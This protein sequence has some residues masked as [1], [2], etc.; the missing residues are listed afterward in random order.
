MS[1]K[2][3]ES[4][5]YHGMLKTSSEVFNSEIEFHNDWADSTSM[6]DRFVHESFESPLALENRFAL[7]LMGDLK[8]KKLLDVGT[9]LG[10][11]AVYFALQGAEVTA[12]DISPRMI[13]RAKQLA[14]YHQTQIKGIVCPAEKLDLPDNHVDICYAANVLHHVTDRKSTLQEIHR[15]LKPN[16]LIVSWDP[17]AYN[18]MINVYRW[19]ADKVR[20]EHEKPLGFN[21]VQEYQEFFEH[22]EHHEF[23]LSA[24]LI[25]VK[26]Y[27]VDRIH[28]NQDRY[29]KRILK[30]GPDTLAW[31]KPLLSLD[32]RLLRFPPLRYMA[33]TILV[34]ARKGNTVAQDG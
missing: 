31:L 16:G 6:E 20:T 17:L 2:T 14:S 8:G 23:W 11:T 9:G 13:E 12:T 21:I 26:Y 10:E 34:A 18:P 27:L 33:W 3:V 29:W 4:I 32:H 30:E 7:N 19:M 15:V 28:P 24:L 25:F 22:V 5:V 1:S